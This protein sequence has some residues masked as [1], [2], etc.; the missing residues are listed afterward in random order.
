MGNNRHDPGAEPA[1]VC[2]G[3]PFNTNAPR[4]PLSR[5][6]VNTACTPARRRR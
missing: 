6:L 2:R 5:G 3:R 4:V 1:P